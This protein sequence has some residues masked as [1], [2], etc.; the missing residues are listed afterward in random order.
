V[1]ITAV[2]IGMAIV[3][4]LPRLLPMLKPIKPNLKF[5]RYIPISIFSAIVFSE[6]VTSDLKVLAGILT[7]LVAW[8][9]KNMLIT[10]GFG[11]GV[12]YVLKMI[13]A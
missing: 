6:L 3:T 11:I 7:F 9:S 4:F 5:M 2:I 12:F 8:R 13:L 10:I 1:E